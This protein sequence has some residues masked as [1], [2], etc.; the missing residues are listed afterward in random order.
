MSVL[1]LPFLI[2]TTTVDV[3]VCLTAFPFLNSETQPDEMKKETESVYKLILVLDF[4]DDCD[5]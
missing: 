4:L 3:Y 1:C 5:Q 2:V